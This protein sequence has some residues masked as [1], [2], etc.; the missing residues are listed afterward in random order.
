MMKTLQQS[1]I[2][3]LVGASLTLA[4]TGSAAAQEIPT[5][6]ARIVEKVQTRIFISQSTLNFKVAAILE[7]QP[8]PGGE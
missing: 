6:A 7:N 3:V 4:L 5:G 8:T 2:A 1:A